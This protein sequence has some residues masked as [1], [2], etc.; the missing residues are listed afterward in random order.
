[1]G[2]IHL[3][4]AFSSVCIGL[5][6]IRE[7]EV[8]KSCGER[9]GSTRIQLWSIHPLQLRPAIRRSFS[10]H[11]HHHHRHRHLSVSPIMLGGF[12]GKSSSGGRKSLRVAVAGDKGTGKSSLISAVASETFPD[13]VPR[14]LPPTTLPADAYPDYIPITIIDTPSRSLSNHPNCVVLPELSMVE[15]F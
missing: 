5:F 15:T 8:N 4:K 11:H 12:G 2:F 6:K 10:L 7:A 9:V 14:V 13:N 3:L 1:M